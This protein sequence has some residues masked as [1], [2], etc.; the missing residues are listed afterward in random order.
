MTKSTGVGRGGARANAGRK[1]ADGVVSV[2][3]ITLTLDEDT[4]RVAYEL[5]DGNYGVGIRRAIAELLRLREAAEEVM[6]Y[7][8]PRAP[9]STLQSVAKPRG[10]LRTP[11]KQDDELPYDPRAVY[12]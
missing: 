7:V 11:T 12:D 9:V 5:G 6:G 2:G 8:S 1:T 3:S 10:I 4:E